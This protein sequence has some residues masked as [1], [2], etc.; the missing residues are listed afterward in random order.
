[1][2]KATWT[3][4]DGTRVKVDVEAFSTASIGD[5]PGF[6]PVAIISDPTNNFELRY[7]ELK[8]LQKDK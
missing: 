4:Q 3:K 6:R 7:V 8:F 1:M 5:G 2:F